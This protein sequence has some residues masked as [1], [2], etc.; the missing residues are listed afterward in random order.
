MTSRPSENDKS[1]L[2]TS[3]V[4]S[5]IPRSSLPPSSFPSP[6]N[7]CPVNHEQETG[8]DNAT[9]NW[10]Y[11]SEKMFF[12]AMR[13]K[14]KAGGSREADMRTVVPMHNAVNERAWNEI[15]AWEAPYMGDSTQ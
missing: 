13:R 15:R 6:P 12:D 5:S 14:G 9:G 8:S 10:I 11:P 7:A 2:S 3:R 1:S 4:V